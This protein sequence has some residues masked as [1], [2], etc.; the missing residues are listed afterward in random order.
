MHAARGTEA[1]L[2]EGLSL[3]AS[4]R[5]R[6]AGLGEQQ[7]GE[8]PAS[9]DVRASQEPLAQNKP[10]QGK[11]PEEGLGGAHGTGTDGV[12]PPGRPPARRCGS[13][14]EAGEWACLGSAEAGQLA[15]DSLGQRPRITDVP[16]VRAGAPPVPRAKWRGRSVGEQ[17]LPLSP[18]PG[19]PG[20]DQGPRHPGPSLSQPAGDPLA[21][22]LLW[23]A[24][25]I[26]LSEG[27]PCPLHTGSAG[28]GKRPGGPSCSFS[29][30]GKNPGPGQRLPGWQ[31]A[32]CLHTSIFPKRDPLSR[33]LA[34][35]RGDSAGKPLG[36]GL[37]SDP[38][39]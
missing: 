22:T 4:L 1:P 38:D 5:P 21:A 17:G 8:Q 15:L 3:P 9:A 13:Q 6:V 29:R 25:G 24:P 34:W 14:R 12:A 28:R 16:G 7:A 35:G 26:C 10:V 19:R 37:T 18:A 27:Q 36:H 11:S 32:S 31:P 39:L 20:R 33:L 23:G 30:K 2:G